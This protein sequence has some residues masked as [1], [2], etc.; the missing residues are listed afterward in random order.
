MAHVVNVGGR[1]FNLEIGTGPGRKPLR[2]EMAPGAVVEIEDAYARVRVRS[3]GADPLPSIVAQMTDGNVLPA[4]DPKA[5]ALY[6]AWL[7]R[8]TSPRPAQAPQQPQA[9]GR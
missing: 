4:S 6:E 2:Y 1:N 5:K 7:E 9:R 3:E 8:Q